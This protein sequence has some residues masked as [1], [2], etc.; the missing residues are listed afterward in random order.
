MV[1]YG[2]DAEM[3]HKVIHGDNFQF[4]TYIKTDD[5]HMTASNKILNS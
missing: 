2:G 1:A 4:I 5:E 3:T